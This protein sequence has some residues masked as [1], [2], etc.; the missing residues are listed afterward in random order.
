MLHAGLADALCSRPLELVIHIV[1][2]DQSIMSSGGLNEL[3]TS[4]AAHGFGGRVG[5]VGN[6]IDQVTIDF[7]GARVSL[8]RLAP[9]Q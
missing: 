4:T 2:D 9:I 5:K 6:G 8:E 3:L 1:G 7:S